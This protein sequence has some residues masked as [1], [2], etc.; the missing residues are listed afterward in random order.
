[1][2]HRTAGTRLATAVTAVLAA[3]ALGAG[4]LA[5]AP[6]ASAEAAEPVT[7]ERSAVPATVDLD[8]NGG[9]A[10]MGWTLS[11]ADAY[12]TVTLTH[13]ASGKWYRQFVHSPSGDENFS[14]E[15]DGLI[16]GIDV[17]NGPWTLHAEAEPN[18]GA[19]AADEE[20]RQ[21][22]VTRAANPHDYGNNGSTDVL[23]RDGAGVLW[24]HDLRNRPVS[25]QIRT[26]QRSVVGSGWNTYK[27]IEAV[28][29]IA[30]SVHGD[31]VALDG[32]G[33]L[34]HYLGKGDNTFALRTRVGSG[35]Q[36]YNKIT[37]GSDL[38]GDGR[39]DLLATDTAGVLWSYRGTGDAARPFAGRVRIGSGWGAYDQI[40]ATGNIAGGTGGDLVARDRDG[41]LWMYLG[42]GDG[43]FTGRMRVGGG[44]Q[45]FSQLVGAGDVDGDGRPDLVAYGANG[46]YVYR[47]NGTVSGAFTRLTTNLYAGEGTKYTGVA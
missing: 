16:D 21:L 18:D 30:G 32:T 39:S 20:T 47:A 2:Q 4:T 8:K 31:L 43:T 46:T 42:K 6:A 25:G 17:P 33:V 13:P 24:R 41:V 11:R 5:L 15:W 1:M 9:R 23:A 19:G 44:W 10:A 36:A 28:G 37:G 38:T 34:W 14:F 27:Q 26:T 40:V 3:A 45:A 29:N 35:W 7:I 22:T 12:L